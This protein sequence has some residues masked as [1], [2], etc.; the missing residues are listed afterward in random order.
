MEKDVGIIHLTLI[1]H[2]N[3]QEVSTTKE[4][5][6]KFGNALLLSFNQQNRMNEQF[7]FSISCFSIYL[8]LVYISFNFIVEN[9]KQ[10]ITF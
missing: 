1:I 8:V 7:F 6:I 4:D 2:I 9:K 10:F 3:G 5:L